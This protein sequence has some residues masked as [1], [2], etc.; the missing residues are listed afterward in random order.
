MTNALRI[1]IAQGIEYLIEHDVDIPNHVLMDARRHGALKGGE[2]SGNFGH[3]GR[4]G[5]VGG[6]GA[7]GGDSGTTGKNATSN[8]AD[9]KTMPSSYKDAPITTWKKG[10]NGIIA[11]TDSQQIGI[12]TQSYAWK[13]MAAYQ[14]D[15]YE[16][17]WQSTPNPDHV[18][19]HEYA[20]FWGANNNPRYDSLK[21]R[22][23]SNDK[24]L[25]SVASQVSKYATTNAVEFLSE[26]YAGLVY[27]N[28]YSSEVMDLYNGYGG[29]KP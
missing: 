15:A 4:P 13:D 18:I 11:T 8:Y 20:H 22:F 27:G 7:G 23:G 21:S 14:K 24:H 12:N 16:K 19:I 5:E 28:N 17:G 2:G 10:K 9:L 3:E 29:L 25:Y 26:T 1:S 6:S